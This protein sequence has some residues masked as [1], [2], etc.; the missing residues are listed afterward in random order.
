MSLIYFM[1]LI[2]RSNNVLF[3]PANIQHIFQMKDNK[4]DLFELKVLQKG[5]RAIFAAE[6]KQRDY[7]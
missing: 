3:H 4:V 5:K 1:F 7:D 6:N 2:D